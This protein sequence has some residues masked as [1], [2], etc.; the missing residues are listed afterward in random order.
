MS[1]PANACPDLIVSATAGPTVGPQQAS[2]REDTVLPSVEPSVSA[3]DPAFWR[4]DTLPAHDECVCG[5][6]ACEADRFSTADCV[7]AL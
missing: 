1:V 6:G 2:E 7:W 3:V 4:V 5:R